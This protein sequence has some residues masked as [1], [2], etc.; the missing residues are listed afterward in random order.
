MTISEQSARYEVP[1]HVPE[2]LVYEWDHF[3]QPEIRDDPIGAYEHLHERGR[4]LFSPLNGGFWFLTNYADIHE[5]LQRPDLWSSKYTSVPARDSRLLPLSL[6]APDHA[7]YRRLI[8]PAF[9]P[10][11]M[12]EL[13]GK[14]RDLCRSLIEPIKHQSEFDFLEVFA[15]PFPSTIFTQMFGLP[16]EEWPRFGRWAHLTIQIG[17]IAAR[18]RATIEVEDYLKDLVAERMSVRS[19]DMLSFLLDVEIE[20]DRLTEEDVL[21][22]SLLL[23]MAGLDTVTAS[24]GF[25]FK[26]LA[27]HPLHREQIIDDPSVIPGAVEEL[28]RYHSNIV[29]A[30]TATGDFT[31]AGA[32]V[33]EGD[34]LAVVLAP[35]GRD[36]QAF[37]NAGTVDFRREPNRHLA[38][39][40]GP[41]RCVG[42]HLARHELR[43]ALEEWHR[44]IPNYAIAP[45][46]KLSYHGA[47]VMG[48]EALPM[49]VG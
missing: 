29:L 7:K 20:G 44:A 28:L 34:R 11:R 31:F 21:A 49:T 45:G 38:F 1:A 17:D 5:A 4:M 3:A 32:P 25:F 24:L 46:T 42:S 16:S 14:M 26:F 37:P 22:F 12:A 40:A 23:F 18:D 43:V 27:E 39:S 48:L 13:E 6:D 8:N 33:K 47:G 2:A 35:S 41:H 10:G 36:P 19:D 9:A 15:R 30:R